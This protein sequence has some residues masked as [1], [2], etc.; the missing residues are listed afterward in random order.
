MKNFV[1]ATSKNWNGTESGSH[2]GWAAVGAQRSRSRSWRHRA[3][4]IWL[5]FHFKKTV[6]RQIQNAKRSLPERFICLFTSELHNS[7]RRRDLSRWNS[8]LM[9]WSENGRILIDR[10]VRPSQERHRHRSPHFVWLAV[11]FPLLDPSKLLK[12][13][14]LYLQEQ[15]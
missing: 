7:F 4:Q 14:L 9:P 3:H 6:K 12:M 15:K 1:R 5:V 2:E 13:K 10:R 11:L 8:G